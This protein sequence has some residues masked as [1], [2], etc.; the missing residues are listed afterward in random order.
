MGVEEYIR[1][2]KQLQIKSGLEEETKHTMAKFLRGLNPNIAE[3]VELQP[4]WSFKDVCK[5]A[6]KVKKHSKN[7]RSFLGSYSLPNI[8]TKPYVQSKPRVIPR[9]EKSQDKGKDI[10]KEF[11]KKLDGKRCFKCHRYGY[12]HANFPNRIAEID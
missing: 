2:F 8:Q 5:L 10:I 11:P 6:I 9:E 12:F 4:Y 3:K 7:K 1:E